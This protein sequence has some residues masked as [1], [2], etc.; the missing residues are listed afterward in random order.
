[1]QQLARNSALRAELVRRGLQ[2]AVQFTFNRTAEETLRVYH[3]Y[4]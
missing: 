3:A 1:M 4:L 2:Q